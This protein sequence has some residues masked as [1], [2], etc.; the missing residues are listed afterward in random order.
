MSRTFEMSVVRGRC[1]R[2]ADLEGDDH[3]S[4]AE[5]NALISEKYGELHG[6]VADVGSRYFETTATIT[7]T[8]ATSYD[9]PVDH[10]E[11]VCIDHVSSDGTRRRLT[12]LHV[13]ERNSLAGSTGDAYAYT[14]VDDQIFLYPNPTSGTYELLYMPQPP[15]L[16]EYADAD[17]VDL[18]NPAGEA[19]LIWGV[20]V[21]A[22]SKSESDVRLAMER[23][24]AAK[25]RLEY[26]AAK[27]AVG[28]GRRPTAQ[29]EE[30]DETFD[31]AGWRQWR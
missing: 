31:P 3:I 4:D 5:W 2:R 26:W 20:C 12:R 27:N 24:A 11:T 13:T 28:D 25:Q 1:Q 17:L 19:F 29:S 8:G 21:L 23:E 15:D 10:H 22:K 6:I 7:A 18:I 9:E 16:S 14:H 30:V